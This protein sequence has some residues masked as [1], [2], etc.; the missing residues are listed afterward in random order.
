[1]SLSLVTTYSWTGFNHKPGFC[2]RKLKGKNYSIRGFTGKDFHSWFHLP[3]H[4]CLLQRLLLNTPSY[5]SWKIKLLSLF[6]GLTTLWY[7]TSWDEF[8]VAWAAVLLVLSTVSTWHMRGSQLS[9]YFWFLCSVLCK[10]KKHPN[11]SQW[12]SDRQIIIQG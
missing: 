12:D 4:F 9:L 6:L 1:M 8:S 10:V 7:Q 11:F 3:F 5:K 2:P